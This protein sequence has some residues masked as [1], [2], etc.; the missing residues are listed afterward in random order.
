[1]PSREQNMMGG[2]G[3]TAFVV[4]GIIGSGIFITP[5]SIL[6]N[7]Q[8]VGASLI[9]W[10]LAGIISVIG[11]FCYVELGTSIRKSGGDFAYLCHMQW[12]TVAFTFMSAAN[13]FIVPCYLAIEMETFA[14]YLQR[15]LR[16]HFCEPVHLC[17][18]FGK[19]SIMPREENMM[20]SWG[21]TSHIVG[22]I[23]G[24]G[25]HY[26]NQHFEQCLIWIIAAPIAATLGAFCYVELDTSIRKT[27]GDL[28]ICATILNLFLFLF[29][30]NL[31]NRTGT[32]KEQNRLGLSV[33]VLFLIE[34]EQEQNRPSWN[35][36]TLL[37]NPSHFPINK[38]PFPSC[39]VPA[40]LRTPAQWPSKCKIFGLR[41]QR[42]EVLLFFLNCFSIRGVVARFQMLAM[43]AKIIA[44]GIIIIVGLMVLVT[45]GAQS[46][47]FREPFANT[48]TY[49]GQW[50][51]ALF[52]GLFSY[53]GW[54]ILNFGAED[55]KKSHRS[56]PFAIIV[57]MSTVVTLYLAMNLS[58]FVVLSV[59][60]VQKSNA[61]AMTFAERTLGG[62]LQYAMP[63]LVCIVLI[64]S[65]NATLFQ[66]SRY[67]WAS[68]RER[69]F[70]SFISCINR[71]HD[72]P[73]AALFV[74]VLLSMAFSFLGNLEELI[75]YVAFTIWIIRS[76]TMMT[77]LCIKLKIGAHTRRQ[78]VHEKA[79]RVPLVLPVLFLFICLA[80]VFVT[81]VQSFWASAVGLLILGIGL[82]VYVTF[83]WPHAIQRFGWYRRLSHS[84]NH[85]TC[86]M[87]QI[88][89][90][91]NIELI[92]QGD[93][94][95]AERNV[96]NVP[97]PSTAHNAKSR[98]QPMQ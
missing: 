11:A 28:P 24:S 1:M 61:I 18:L 76:C 86:I 85:T 4:N 68:A 64:G 72:S 80:L 17:L 95:N 49:P 50:V 79:I 37:N 35:R 62:F 67:I 97:P 8:S 94:Q 83:I 2:W 92:G 75:S 14:N 3:A 66:G 47:N 82:A 84:L 88:A 22:N 48:S 90:N 93:Q 43:I 81:I 44:S 91:G 41:D 60:E 16:A 15:G 89:F 25:I 63:F 9:V 46:D 59:P 32:E 13:L 30:S 20:A 71:Q 40:S 74:H 78:G 57:G 19:L 5:T 55:V 31:E 38:Q 96:V 34:Q 54:D 51:L 45:K 7:V 10:L 70:P 87:A 39:R 56:M 52:A 36:K 42:A 98:V 6:N 77:L 12:T 73:R 53:D 65:L 29:C 21:A 26:A 27:G 23:I 69:H 58:Y 33:A